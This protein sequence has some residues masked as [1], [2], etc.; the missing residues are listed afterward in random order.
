MIDGTV[1]LGGHAEA[2][3]A[4]SA[5]D[6]R[7]LGLDVDPDALERCAARLGALDRKSVV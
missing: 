1:G 7:L 5:S 3:L 6:V 2:L 4:S